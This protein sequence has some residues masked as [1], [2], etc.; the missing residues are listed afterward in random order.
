MK[1]GLVSEVFRNGDIAYNVQQITK[2]LIA[3]SEKGLDMLCFGEA[4]LQGFDALSWEYEKDLK[5]AVTQSHDTV[6]SLQDL[7]KAYKIALA[8]GYYEQA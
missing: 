3:C 6:Q 2:R 7:A 5:R 4:F 8:F 1:I